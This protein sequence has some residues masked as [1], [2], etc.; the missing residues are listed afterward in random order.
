MYDGHLPTRFVFVWR[1][2]SDE[3]WNGVI[4]DLVD[5]VEIEIPCDGIKVLEG[6]W[7][8]IASETT[9][10]MFLGEWKYLFMNSGIREYS[11]VL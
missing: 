1:K 3:I 11:F 9:P 6:V 4:R 8:R 5:M 7:V 2:E 10:R